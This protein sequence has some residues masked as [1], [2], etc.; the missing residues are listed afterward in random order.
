ME[1][2]AYTVVACIGYIIVHELVAEYRF[3]K[4]MR[5]HWKRFDEASKTFQ[6]SR[7]PN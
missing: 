3:R 2:I 4:R 7:S 5:G 1:Q 6:G